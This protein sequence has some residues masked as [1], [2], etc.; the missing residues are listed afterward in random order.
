MVANPLLFRGPLFQDMTAEERAAI[1]DLLELHLFDA[2]QTLLQEGRQTPM[3]WILT[4]G[5]CQVVKQTAPRGEQELAVLEP[6]GI[7]GE[8]SFFQPG[9][10]SAT[11]RTLTEVE[12]AQLTRERFEQLELQS[13][14]AALKLVQNLLRV[15]SERL[16]RMDDWTCRLVDHHGDAGRREEWH[17]FRNKLYTGW[18]F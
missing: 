15:V 5:H 9:P 10:H 7:F 12:V 13:H 2:G 3:L 17:E 8:M 1:L 16:R 18:N 14:R 4:R 6:G 11:V